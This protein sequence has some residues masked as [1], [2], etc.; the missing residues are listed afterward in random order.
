MQKKIMLKL[1]IKYWKLQKNIYKI[2]PQ[3]LTNGKNCDILKKR[4]AVIGKK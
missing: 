2:R 3:Y 4:N 1:D